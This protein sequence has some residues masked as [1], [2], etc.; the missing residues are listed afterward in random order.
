MSQEDISAQTIVG[1]L[2]KCHYM[3]VLFFCSALCTSLWTFGSRIFT[4]RDLL[5]D[6]VH[7]F[8]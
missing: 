5:S 2:G 7:L 8:L 6:S 4:W 3:I 1:I